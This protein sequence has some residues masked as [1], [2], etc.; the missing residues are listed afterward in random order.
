MKLNCPK[1]VTLNDILRD[2][3]RCETHIAQ[4]R[5]TA[6]TAEACGR[7]IIALARLDAARELVEGTIDLLCPFDRN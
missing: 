7:A 2:I 3:D 6:A 1:V 5:D 4:V